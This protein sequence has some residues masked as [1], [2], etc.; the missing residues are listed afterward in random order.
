MRP[1]NL[2]PP[3]QRRGERAPTRTGPASYAVVALLAVALAAVTLVVTTNNDISERRSEIAELEARE[4]A[5]RAEADRLRS[6]ADFASIQQAREATVTSLAHSRFDWERV[7]RELAIVI[8]DDVWLTDLTAT[9]TPSVQLE[10][11]TDI[12]LR[13]GIAGPALE[14]VGCGRS[15]ESVAGFVAA[16]E[17]IDGVTRVAVNKSERPGEVSASESTASSQQ[18][19]Q[20]VDCRTR[21]FISKFEV[22]AAFDEVQV[23]PATQLPIPPAAAPAPA[24]ASSDTTLADG[25]AG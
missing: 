21:S 24:A 25:A 13:A 14:I 3:E 11:S 16:L 17:D 7:L 19:G 1:V 18:T 2:I 6:F 15:H 4:A 8:P 9:V 5:A 22:V 12:A 10:E 23:D 20:S